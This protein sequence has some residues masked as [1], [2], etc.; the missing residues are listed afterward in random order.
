MRAPPYTAQTPQITHHH[1]NLLKSTVCTGSV[2]TTN[3][4]PK[5]V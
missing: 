4:S 5:P 2:D 1:I 3:R